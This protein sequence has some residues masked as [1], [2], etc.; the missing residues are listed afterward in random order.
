MDSETFLE[1]FTLFIQP[2][3]LGV[4]LMQ[5]T[6]SGYTGRAAEV[7]NLDRKDGSGFF[8]I[9]EAPLAVNIGQDTL[10]D[11]YKLEFVGDS[12]VKA[13]KYI[14]K[15]ALIAVT[16]SLRFEVWD[17]AEGKKR[18]KAV[19]KVFEIQLPGKAASI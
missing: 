19:V 16:G 3:Y 7:K 14:G 1:G 9:A 10:P 12:L 17:D 4:N 8:Q 18:S 15:G 2:Y 6:L 13:A 11:W 5:V